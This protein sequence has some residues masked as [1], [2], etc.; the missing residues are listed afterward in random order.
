MKQKQMNVILVY[1]LIS[2]AKLAI[3]KTNAYYV[4]KS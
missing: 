3:L 2:V 1:W 4:E